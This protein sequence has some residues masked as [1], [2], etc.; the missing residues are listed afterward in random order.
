AA[1]SLAVSPPGLVVSA[2]AAPVAFSVTATDAHGN[3]TTDLGALTWSTSGPIS[4]LVATGVLDPHTAG[5][6]AVIATSSHGP[7]ASAPVTIAPGHAAVLA[8]APATLDVAQGASPVAFTVTASDG[9]GNATSDLGTITW[10]SAGGI[11]T[12]DPVSGVLAPVAPGTGTVR[13]TSSYGAFDDTGAIRI[14]RPVALSATLAAPAVVDVGQSF[15]V[16]MT[17]GNAGDSAATG[18][19]PCAL[20]PSGSGAA[21]LVSGPT[22]PTTAIAPG[23]FAS[24]SFTFTATTAGSLVLSAC[25]TGSD[26]FTLQAVTAP[27]ASSP[28]I[29]IETGA[30]LTA[31]LSIPATLGR[32]E[33]FTAT[34]LVTN[35]GQAAAIGVQPSLLVRTGTGGAALSG[36]APGAT[37][38]AGG[39]NATFTWTY[40]TSSV[41]TLRLSGSASG[42]DAATSATVT[43]NVAQTALASIVE[44]DLVATDPF[45]DGSKFAFVA[46][47]EGEL[48]L[49]PNDAGTEAEQMFSDG[50]GAAT[51]D[52]AFAP[53]TTGGNTM[54][55]TSAAPYPA[56]GATGCTANT[57]ACGPD[58][59]NGRGMFTTVTVAGQDW[60]IA[61][62]A[63]TSGNLDYVYMTTGSAPTLELDYVDLTSI[64]NANA[65][66][67]SA[68]A[69]V[70][71]VVYIGMAS[72]NTTYRPVLGAL[73]TMPAAPGLD[74]G[75]TDLVDLNADSSKLK[76]TSVARI[77]A[78]AAFQS[79]LVVANANAWFAATVAVPGDMKTNASNWHE[80]TPGGGNYTNKTSI[81]DSKTSN[82]TPADRAVP[83]LAQF[84]GRLFVARNTTTGPQLWSCNPAQTGDPTICDPP[85]WTLVAPNTVNCFLILCSGDP[86]ITSFDDGSLTAITMVVAT[87]HYLYVG[88]D[89]TNGV[90]VFR[91]ANP[92]AT[93]QSD[94]EGTGGCNAASHDANHCDGYGGVGLG[95]SA[96]RIFDAKALTFSGTTSVWMTIGDGSTPVALVSLP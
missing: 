6:G 75:P 32:G 90:E 13:A 52:F 48:M 29:A 58:N 74:P 30:A 36:P 41:G 82:I 14:R 22:P 17:I 34:M 16:T 45:G 69:A 26:S 80:I 66:A 64:S 11:G 85:D 93:S 1:A 12:I 55:N 38:I 31:S 27:V 3:A 78:M 21:T 65:L 72:S 59:E 4:T 50:T 70:N 46:G 62:G 95:T 37:T 86:L 92:A 91:T 35:T 68:I 20:V 42:S 94:F 23:G 88:F 89:G 40:T 44:A 2:D 15:T 71:D 19:A 43:S 60:L 81:S 47:Y 9:D 49:G 79:R 39:G 25:A 10:S 53:D 51:L 73:S 54:Q 63:R 5:S 87:A 96:T 8:V 61:G 76:G 56:L 84:G 28:A 7:S 83:Q 24:Q 33:P 77:D 57:P 67:I 18:V